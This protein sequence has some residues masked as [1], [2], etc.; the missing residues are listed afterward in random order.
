MVTID[1]YEKKIAQGK[2]NGKKTIQRARA[3][4]GNKTEQ[5]G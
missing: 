4:R 1:I 3:S 2:L 5:V